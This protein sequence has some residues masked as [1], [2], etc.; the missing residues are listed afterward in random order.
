MEMGSEQF[1]QL[2]KVLVCVWK[3]HTTY[4]DKHIRVHVGKY[5]RMD[6]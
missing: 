2:G 4:F 5:W 1:R 6:G 3:Q